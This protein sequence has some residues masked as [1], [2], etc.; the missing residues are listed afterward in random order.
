MIFSPSLVLLLSWPCLVL[1]ELTETSM[2][3]VHEVISVGRKLQTPFHS[4]RSYAPRTLVTDDVSLSKCRREI[5]ELRSFPL[6]CMT[7]ATA[8]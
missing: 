4:I 6:V 2:K 3:L 5:E 8:F 1:G 7:R